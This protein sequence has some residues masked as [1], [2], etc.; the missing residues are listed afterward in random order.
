MAATDIQYG[1]L[2]PVLYTPDFTFLRYVLD[3]KTALYQQGLKSASSSY[4]NLK[5]ELTDP[6]N[7]QKRDEYLKDAQGQLQKIASSDL[8]IQQNVNLANSI[9]DP[10]ATDKAFLYDAYHTQR[11]KTELNKEEAWKNSEDSD[12][13]KKYN[14]EIAEWVNR[15]LDSLRNG[16]GDANNYKVQGRT[17]Q[18]FVDAQDILTDA[19]KVQG[20]KMKVDEL[21]APYIT[22]VEGG[23]QFAPNYE[24]FANNILAND[25]V[26]QK[27]TAILGQNRA[28][29]I[30]EKYKTDPELSPI[31]ANKKPEEM[32]T[33][34]AIKTFDEHRIAQKD[35]LD[36]LNKNLVSETASITATISGPDAAK[37]TKGA[38]DIA[39]GNNTSEEAKMYL[40]I[41]ERANNRN[42][43][44]GK[45]KDLQ[46]DYNNTYGADGKMTDELRRN[47]LKNFTDN[48]AAFLSDIQFKNDVT[49]FS[50]IKSSF[51]T[52]TVKEDRAYVD[53]TVA[54]TNAMA[55][56][57]K[58]EDT[59]LDNVRADKKLDLDERKE[60]FK[61]SLKTGKKIKNADGTYTT[62]EPE[63]KLVDY[64][65]TQITT[66]QALNDLKSKV[67]MASAKALENATSNFGSFY[68]LQSMGM[69]QTKVGVLKG[70]FNRYFS[71]D[72]KS[73]FKGTA[74]ENKALS[75]AYTTMWAFSR[76]NPGNTFLQQERASQASGSRKA[77]LTIN[78]L[79]DLLDKALTG[80]QVQTDD[81][82]RAKVAMVEY[83][84]NTQVIQTV[85]TALEKGKKVVIE[86]LKSD[87][88]YNGMFVKRSDGT[89]DLVGAS[90]IEANLPKNIDAQIRKRIGVEYANGTLK[91]N[92]DVRV[93][94]TAVPKDGPPVTETITF[95]DGTTLVNY[96]SNM[97]MPR[98]FP[99]APVPET[100]IKLYQKINE[101]V[102]VPYFQTATGTVSASPAFKLS[103]TTKQD[104]LD[105]LAKSTQ[106]NSNIFDYSSGTANQSQI[107][108]EV[109]D[110]IRNAIYNKDN[111]ADVSLY[112]SSPLNNGGQ[113]VAITF[114]EKTGTEKNPAPG[115]SGKTFYFPITPSPASPKVFHIFNEI[116]EMNEYESNKQKG[117]P[118]IID[119]FRADGAYVEIRPNKPGDNTGTIT[120]WYKPYNAVTKT[121]SD[122]FIKGDKDMEF[123]LGKLTFPEIKQGIYNEFLYPY[124]TSTLNYKKQVAANTAASGATPI[125]TSSILQSLIH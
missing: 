111:I 100:Y 28:E 1:G 114:N 96:M 16:K 38:A 104:V 94:G 37:Y 108:P 14:S 50:N 56:I 117:T 84:N 10:I 120:T 47:Y 57:N 110:K 6:V 49:R 85:N 102:P 107:S 65:A 34:Y 69:D 15:D 53:V 17:A 76:N 67:S 9:F 55:T 13:R 59:H 40:A 80:Y 74:E 92:V 20:F 3:K 27:Q 21:G 25:Q 2:D 121:Y 112:T 109:Q 36:A 83:K 98:F 4:N 51:Y 81:E 77:G 52:R 48:P 119:T 19:V 72:D 122:K 26:Y 79:P 70:M 46:S 30:I 113:A 39:A 11:I 99:K 90:D 24:T 124:M 93:S 123:D 60:D 89:M 101:G 22:T 78:E 31:W 115:Y 12:E 62:V 42:S 125:T 54:K 29:K 116:N 61:E 68:M 82:M 33:D 86:K 106:T 23:P 35:H 7:S 103:G 63:I 105:D 45:L 75:E 95:G 91:Y 73:T 97:N 18:A 5:K 43:L 58:I 41:T 71:S 44:D 8:S 118:Y 88:D 87:P 66:T 32:Y 64:S